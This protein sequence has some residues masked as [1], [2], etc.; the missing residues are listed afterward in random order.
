MRS[1]ASECPISPDFYGDGISDNGT[2]TLLATDVELFGFFERHMADF[3]VQPT[4]S[5]A[6]VSRTGIDDWIRI[7]SIGGSSSPEASAGNPA[8]YEAN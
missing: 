5:V 4:G 2:A 6:D 8:W 1:V 7:R 3:L